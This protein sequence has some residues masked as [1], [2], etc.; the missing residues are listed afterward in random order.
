MAVTVERVRKRVGAST[1][2]DDVIADKLAQAVELVDNHIAE[3]VPDGTDPPEIP[4]AILDGVVED[5]AAELF[6]QAKA[7]NGIL[8]QQFDAG[9]MIAST[10]VRIGRDPMAPARP[11]LAPWLP[12]L[13]F[14]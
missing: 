2:D 12:S 5:V 10:P 11:K 3:S 9:G 1:A 14:A 6:H 8:N 4:A 13:G 7:P